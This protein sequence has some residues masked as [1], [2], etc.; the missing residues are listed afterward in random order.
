MELVAIVVR[1]NDVQQE[2]VLGLQQG[3]KQS[4]PTFYILQSAYLGIET[5]EAKFHLRKHLAVTRRRNG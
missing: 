3:V 4:M 1:G 5:G 2:D